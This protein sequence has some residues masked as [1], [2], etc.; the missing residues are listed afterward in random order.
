[1][2]G[3]EKL[4]IVELGCGCGIVGIVSAHNRT[5]CRV[6]LTDLLEASGLAV[7]NA[8][9]ASLHGSSGISFQALDW[10]MDVPDLPSDGPI[11][12]ILASDCTYNPDSSPALVRTL[13]ALAGQSPQATVI[14][15]MKVR[16]SAE[17]IFFD[18]MQS[19]G[20]V[21][22]SHYSVVLPGIEADND[23]VDIYYFNLRRND[24]NDCSY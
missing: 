24:E 1:M 4:Q 12:V 22:R 9:S 6:I 21:N 7:R 17:I 11:D 2:Q 14:I 3:N 16:H 23:K 8:G 10:E 13:T 18:L 15:A 20:F 19:A 5:N